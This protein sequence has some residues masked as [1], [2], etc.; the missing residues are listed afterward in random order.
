M[1]RVLVTGGTGF[2]GR[3]L[4]R[5]ILEETPDVEVLTLSR[6]ETNIA[7]LQTMNVSERLLSVVG[8]I[9]DIEVLQSVLDGVDTVVHLAS[10]KHVDLCE[11]CTWEAVTTNVNGTMNLLRLFKGDTLVI[12][13]TSRAVT[14]VNCHEATKLLM[15]KLV[16]EQADRQDRDARYMVVRI[17]DVVDP[18]S[19]IG[20][21][22]RRRDGRSKKGETASGYGNG[23]IYT[24]AAVALILAVIQR[25]KNGLT[26]TPDVTNANLGTSIQRRVLKHTRK[27]IAGV[28]AK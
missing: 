28:H 1:K 16:L 3:A 18:D 14:P 23:V 22:V 10:M 15:E 21:P 25:G 11:S 27:P 26:Y 8:D 2:L 7:M 4:V 17:G 6:N 5:K 9:R 12:V 19:C 20:E 24:D 13:S